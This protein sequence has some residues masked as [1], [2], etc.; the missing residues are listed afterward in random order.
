MSDSLTVHLVLEGFKRSNRSS[1]LV[2]TP[3]LILNA[4][5]AILR[6]QNI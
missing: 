3:Y 1:D 2:Q 5:V 4:L 6:K